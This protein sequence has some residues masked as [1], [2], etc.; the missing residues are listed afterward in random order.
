M[1]RRRYLFGEYRQQLVVL[2]VSCDVSAIVT[3]RFDSMPYCRTWYNLQY[4]KV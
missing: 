4:G 3:R 1:R 2:V